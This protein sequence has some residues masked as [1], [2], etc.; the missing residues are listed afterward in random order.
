M[1]ITVGSGSGAY[2]A[3]PDDAR[4]LAESMSEAASGADCR[5]SCC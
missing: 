4:D 1:V 3:T 5:A 2:M